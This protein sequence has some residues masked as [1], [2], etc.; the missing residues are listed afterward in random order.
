MTRRVQRVV[1]LITIAVVLI[2]AG[3]G[4]GEP[5]ETT[6]PSA[7]AT[8]PGDLVGSPV[9]SSAYTSLDTT[10]ARA[11]RF[12]YL[13][14]YAPTGELTPVSAVAF[15][16]R[17]EPPPGGWPIAAVAHAT[18]GVSTDCAPSMYPNLL[19]SVVLATTFLERGFA[20]VLTDY[21][22]LGTPGEHA[23]LEPTTAAYNVID[24]ARAVRSVIDNTSADWLGYGVSQG[25]QAVFRANEVNESY[26]AGLRLMGTM[27]I[28]P[29]LDLRPFVSAMESGTLTAEQLTLI[30]ALLT[31]VQ[32]VHPELDIDD[33]VRGPMRDAFDVFLQCADE[34]T[35]QKQAIVEATTPDDVR[36]VDEAAA[37]RLRDWLGQAA[38]PIDRATAPM[39]IA[40]S[41]GDA[42]VLPSWNVAAIEQ[43][44][45]R[46]DDITTVV[47][48]GQS[49]GI[50]DVGSDAG[51][52]V[53]KRLAGRPTTNNCT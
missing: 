14:T 40:Y 9:D 4:S 29:A 36:P 13:S 48:T 43:A 39:F 31:G 8:A 42:L 7:A 28:S 34:A 27:S 5:A 2:I 20:V 44:C 32:R 3:C 16:P 22:G 21:Q 49:H 10:A 51:D 46:G 41:D 23:Y 11:T 53:L 17:G 15:T 50:L 38:L 35:A 30:P 33:Y 24:S 45:R 52:W 1:C 18:T 47:V 6:T 25:A 19:G 26:G 37:Q 12:R